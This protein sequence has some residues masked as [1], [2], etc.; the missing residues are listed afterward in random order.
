[1]RIGIDLDGTLDR[2]PDL[3]R[4]F[5][6]AAFAKGHDVICVTSRINSEDNIEIV[7]SWMK[8]KD[9]NL[10]TFFVAWQSKVD[11]MKNAGLPVDVWID[12]DPKRCA[13][14]Y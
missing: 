10:P 8:D 3:W 5:I 2:D 11:Y 4:E 12:D 7:E 14:G 6:E 13:M 1:V 9:L